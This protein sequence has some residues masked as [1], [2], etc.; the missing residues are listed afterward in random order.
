MSWDPPSHVADGSHVR[1]PFDDDLGEGV[2]E[3][4][5][6]GRQAHRSDAC[7]LAKLARF[8][9]TSPQSL[10]ADVEDDLGTRRARCRRGRLPGRTQGG[11]GVREVGVMR[12]ATALSACLSEYAV[13]QRLEGV[14]HDGSL[15]GSE[16]AA[17]RDGTVEGRTEAKM[18]PL[19]E[20]GF[21]R[22]RLLLG[23]LGCDNRLTPLAEILQL[24]ST[25]GFKQLSRRRRVGLQS[26]KQ[27][28]RLDRRQLAAA[29][30]LLQLRLRWKPIGSLKVT[31]HHSDAFAALAGD[32]SGR[33]DCTFAL[34]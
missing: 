33:G 22:R 8:Q 31:P 6:D 5:L 32:P 19:A 1:A 23:P 29:Q 10:G 25:R 4:V 21:T 2:P 13:A 30:C 20:P 28:G 24:I 9:F 34:V 11:E 14:T 26:W 16:L 7:D 3:E 27:N 17:N 15:D 12:L 18:P